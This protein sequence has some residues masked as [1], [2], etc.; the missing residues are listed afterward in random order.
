MMEGKVRIPVFQ[1]ADVM[2][3]F[4][5]LIIMNFFRDTVRPLDATHMF[6][7]RFGSLIRSCFVTYIIAPAGNSAHI[8]KALK[9]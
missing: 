5:T 7:R 8:G 6:A 4:I 2:C 3:H 9:I 1:L